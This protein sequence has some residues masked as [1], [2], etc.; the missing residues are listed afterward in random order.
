MVDSARTTSFV[1]AIRHRGLAIKHHRKNWNDLTKQEYVYEKISVTKNNDFVRGGA[2]HQR[3]SITPI[4]FASVM[5]FLAGCSDVVCLQ[6]FHCYTSMMTGNLVMMS[7]SIAEGNWAEALLKLSIITSFFVGTCISRSLSWICNKDRDTPTAAKKRH[8]KVIALITLVMFT[9]YDKM[10]A[11]QMWVANLIPIANGIVYSCANQELNATITQLM[12]GH[13]T[14]LGSSVV[15]R[16][17]GPSYLWNKGSLMSLGI[18]SSFVVGAFAGL[19]LSTSSFGK[20]GPL[21]TLLGFIYAA[22]LALY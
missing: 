21:F 5:S 7:I 16:F 12:T 9:L 15:D 2:I 11:H 4:V 6:R 3:I 10:A 20:D 17:A 22:L 14:K 19:K 8:L 18:I 1:P 13:L